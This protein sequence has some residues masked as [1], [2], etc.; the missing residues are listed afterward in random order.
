MNKGWG[1]VRAG[2]VTHGRLLSIAASGRLIVCL[3]FILV[4]LVLAGCATPDRAPERT[5]PVQVS[6]S[7]W[8]QVDNDIS[9]ASLAARESAWRY[10]EN[11]MARW[12]GRVHDLTE[13][14]FIPWFTGYWTQQWLAVKLAWYKL[15]GGD[16]VDPEVER[17]AKYLQ[18]QYHERVLGPVAEEVNPDAVRA[19]ATTLYVQRLVQNL[20]DVPQRNGVPLGPFE[21]RLAGIPAIASSSPEHSASLFQLLRA[22]PVTDFPAYAALLDRIGRAAG[23][24]GTVPSG[25]R[26]SP[27]ARR[28]SEKLAGRIAASGGASAA[29][30]AVGGVAGLVISLG[31][32]GFG[33]IAH[34]Q[35]RP[36]ME[37]QVRESLDAAADE[38]W[39]VLTED[40][41]VG[42]MSGV[43]HI[44]GEIEGSVATSISQP[45]PEGPPIGE[46]FLLDEP[47]APDEVAEDADE[48]AVGEAAGVS[49]GERY[50]H[51][52]IERFGVEAE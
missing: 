8:W 40:P 25:E 12:R 35:D 48:E 34:A 3:P 36:E 47:I 49:A 2:A 18:A 32:V 43:N 50:D 26:I 30:A 1:S 17:L 7:T 41:V 33:A 28:A 13:E 44:A 11:A 42:V 38:M 9:A 46:I 27:V 52:A 15:G 20:R 10:A 19:Q 22:D 51:D 37:A 21:Q 16:G 39:L 29:A 4:A 5:P 6:E 45:I 23:G 24:E 31:A 14:D